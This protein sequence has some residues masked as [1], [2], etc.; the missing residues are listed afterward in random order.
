MIKWTEKDRL[1]AFSES[2]VARRE[3]NIWRN[4]SHR[5]TVPS[6]QRELAEKAESCRLQSEKYAKLAKRRVGAIKIGRFW[7]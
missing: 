3:A 6:D 7:L 2:V 1:W 5:T 4:A